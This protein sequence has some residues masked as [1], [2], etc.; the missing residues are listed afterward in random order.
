MGRLLAGAALRQ[1]LE[2]DTFWRPRLSPFVVHLGIVDP[3]LGDYLY[4]YGAGQY[5]A[6]R[7]PEP[8][9][10]TVTLDD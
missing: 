8:D 1:E 5:G 4:E 7:A 2:L 6:A 9:T 10:E 3:R